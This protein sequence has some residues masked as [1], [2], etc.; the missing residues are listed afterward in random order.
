MTKATLATYS[1]AATAAIL[2]AI[3]AN[4]NVASLEVATALVDSEDGSTQG[5]PDVRLDN[6]GNPRKARA[7]TAKM[8]TMAR[9]SAL[10]ITY[11]RKAVVTK[12]GRPVTKKTD[13]VARIAARAGVAAEK[14]GGLENAP[15][16][17]LE[18]LV[19]AD[20]DADEDEDREAA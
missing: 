6:D 18:I 2:A 3:Q 4:G 10:G 14:F 12:D 9:D 17:V 1:A 7:I 8:S 13:L 19:S 11:E 5:H 20:F 15:K 16:S